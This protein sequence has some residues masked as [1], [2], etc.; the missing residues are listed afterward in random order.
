LPITR[1]LELAE[2][3]GKPNEGDILI[4]AVGTIGSTY[5]VQPEEFYFKDGNVIWLRNFKMKNVNFF[6]YDF[7]QSDQFFGLLNEITIGSTQN[8]ITIKSLGEQEMYIPDNELLKKYNKLSKC[9]QKEITLKKN[10]KKTLITLKDF[11]LSKMTKIETE[12][13]V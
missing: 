9:F 4:T 5:M 6:I 12:K 13:K 10:E 7:M 1:Y 2:K 3:Y 8:A 11:L